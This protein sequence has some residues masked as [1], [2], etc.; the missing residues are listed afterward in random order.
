[1]RSC[2]WGLSMDGE[3][4][5]STQV[6]LTIGARILTGAVDCGPLCVRKDSGRERTVVEKEGPSGF[7]LNLCRRLGH[8]FPPYHYGKVTLNSQLLST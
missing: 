3:V 1:M 5:T 6:R 2:E 4:R 8:P 7:R